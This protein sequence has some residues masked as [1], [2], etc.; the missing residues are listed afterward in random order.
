[1]VKAPS[2]DI[3]ERLSRE[4]LFSERLR[5]GIIIVFLGFLLT[6]FTIF[7]LAFGDEIDNVFQGNIPRLSRLLILVFLLAYEI[8]V[9]FVI[10]YFIKTGKNPPLFPRY[11]NAL[12]EI[13]VPGLMILLLFHSGGKGMAFFLPPTF[14]YFFFIFL[15]SLRLDFKLSLF[16]GS[17]AALQYLLLYFSV[18]HGKPETFPHPALSYPLLHI[19][20]AALL[21][22]AGLTAGFIAREIKKR[23][24]HVFDSFEERNRV[25]N[26]FGQH[27]SPEVVDKLLNQKMEEKGEIRHVCVM[28]LDIRN[29]TRFSESRGPEEVVAYLNRL[30]TFMIDIVNENKGVINKFLGDGFMAV[31]GAPFSD[32]QDSENAI[33]AAQALVERVR[34]ESRAGTIPETNIGIGLHCGKALTGNIGSH[35]RKEYT[36]IGD[37]VN[38]ASRIEQLNKKFGTSV[39]FSEDVKF[40][41]KQD[42]QPEFLEETMVKGREAP[43][44]IYKLL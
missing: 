12:I 5:I 33:R 4:I 31:F 10:G 30:F 35:V 9:F 2:R 6:F 28:F 43:V 24:H 36:I 1:M 11:I 29:F 25:M 42:V 13:S 18:A 8:A 22:L 3:D 7:I 40:D 26:V 27:V 34:D 44:K 20:K 15:T 14:I 16:T 41:L 19:V 23:I 32:G 17:A 21:F 37:V 38:L 39:L